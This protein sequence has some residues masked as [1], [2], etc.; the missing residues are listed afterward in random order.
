MKKDGIY[1]VQVAYVSGDPRS[2]TVF[3]NSG[4][5]TSEKFPSTGDWSTARRSASNSALKAALNTI[6]FDSGSGYAPDIDR[7]VVPQSV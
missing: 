1:T 3:S 6:T 2:A 5:G 7:I 4:N